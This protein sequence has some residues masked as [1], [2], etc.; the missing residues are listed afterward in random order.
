MKKAFIIALMVSM[1]STIPAHSN[2]VQS[3]K[4]NDLRHQIETIAD[5][6]PATVGVAVL[7]DGRHLIAVNDSIRYPMMSVY[8]LHQA[9]AVAD[10]LGRAKLPLSTKIHVPKEEL[11][12]N[13]YSPLRDRY[14]HGN[15][16]MPVDSLLTYTLQQSDNNA[17]DILFAH[18]GGPSAID[19]YIRS[20]GMNHFA[21]SATE[22]DMHRQMNR[23]QDNWTRPSDAALLLEKLVSDSICQPEYQDF[24]KRTLIECRTGTNRLASP[25]KASTAIIG[26]KTGTSDQNER[27]EI[28]GVNDIGFVLLPDGRHYTIAVFVKDSLA[29]LMDTEAI[30]ARISRIAYEYVTSKRLHHNTH[31]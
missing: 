18:F 28:I 9:I 22:D 27:G 15:I 16:D 1:L 4:H 31:L 23:C 29:S 13:T 25:L 8:K 10:S 2:S 3:A 14:P 24:I 21:I 30:I 7:I 20:L 19:G 11:R 17:C 12:Q 5:D 6:A 26:H